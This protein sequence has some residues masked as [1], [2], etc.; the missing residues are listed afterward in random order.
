MKVLLSYSSLII[1]S[2]ISGIVVNR[3]QGLSRKSNVCSALVI[4]ED[5]SIHCYK[6]IQSPTRTSQIIA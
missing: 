2:R 1:Y 6:P 3:Y 5:V 4:G